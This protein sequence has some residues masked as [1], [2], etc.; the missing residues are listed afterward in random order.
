MGTDKQYFDVAICGAGLAGLSLARQLTLEQP[1]LSIAL[2]DRHESPLPVAA[3][4]VGESTV[5]FGAHYLSDYLQLNDYMPDAHLKKLGLRFFFGDGRTPVE[6]RPELGLSGFAE[7][8]AYQIDRGRL[9]NDL[10]DMVSQDGA[11]LMEG[12]RVTSINMSTGNQLHTVSYTSQEIDKP[13][14]LQCRWLIDAT[15]RRRLIQRKL[16]LGRPAKGHACS[17]AWF[18]LSGRVDVDHL[19]SPE[20]SAWHARVPGNIRYYSTNHLCGAGYW[21]WLIPLSS[22]VTSVG[23]VAREDMHPFEEYR[24]FEKAIAWLGRHEPKLAEY[25]KGQETLDFLAM[26]QYSYTSERIFSSDRWACIGEASVF[27]DPFYSPG[28][29]FIALA[30]T[31]CC[32]LIGRDFTGQTQKNQAEI[33]SRYIIE[34]NNRLT[35]NIQR[36]YRYLGDEIVSLA[37]GLW[38]YSAAWG[39]MCLPLFNRVFTDADKQLALRQTNSASFLE[40]ANTMQSFLEQWFEIRSKRG[41]H[42]S[43]QFFDYLSVA[44]LSSF[45]TSNLRK[46]DSMAGLTDQFRANHTLYQDLSQA[47]FLLAVEDLYPQRLDYFARAEQLNVLHMDLN[48]ETWDNGCVF[49]TETVSQTNFRKIY[50]EIR[51]QLNTVNN[52]NGLV[53]DGKDGNKETHPGCSGAVPEEPGRAAG[54]D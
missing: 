5:E 34:L 23:I 48:P 26:K 4:K 25:I 54:G 22:D 45:R 33:Y 29:D 18:R 11:V 53:S 42:L 9:E 24:N 37:R 6:Q 47:L 12:A 1:T 15:G 20:Q 52:D 31:F 41:G 19:V 3:W 38:D 13:Q 27:S 32:E 44:W 28:T 7:V 2:L 36:G 16:N 43:F 17:S 46:I 50:Q 40:L 35:Q 10:R 8:S 39:Q 51:L 30:N 49:A 14:H 21:V